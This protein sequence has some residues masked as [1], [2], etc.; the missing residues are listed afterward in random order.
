MVVNDI[1]RF[2]CPVGPKKRE[3]PFSQS[4]VISYWLAICV[5][6]ALYLVEFVEEAVHILRGV[7]AHGVVFTFQDVLHPF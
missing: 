4:A 6:R 3:Q 1:S 2:Q 7:E 5:E